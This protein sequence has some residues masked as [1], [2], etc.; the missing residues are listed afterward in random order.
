MKYRFQ[1]GGSTRQSTP[2]GRRN[3]KSMYVDYGFS[4][5]GD[6]RRERYL[7]NFYTTEAMR[8]QA[9]KLRSL[10]VDEPLKAQVLSATD[11]VLSDLSQRGDYENM[12]TAVSRANTEYNKLAAPLTEN[13]ANYTS[14]QERLQ[15]D[16]EE[17]RLNSRDYSR[18]MS[19]AKSTY[20]GLEMD[21][22]GN[23]TNYF[24]GVDP[25]YDPDIPQLMYKALDGLVPDAQVI[26]G[27]KPE[28]NG[29]GSKYAIKTTDGIK[30][31]DAARVDGIMDMVMNEPSVLSY[32]Q[33]GAVLDSYDMD[34]ETARGYLQQ[35]IANTQ[36]N[37]DALDAAIAEETNADAKAQLVAVKNQLNKGV[38]ELTS[39]AESDDPLRAYQ[40][41]LIRKENARYR[42][43]AEEKYTYEQTET[44]RAYAYNDI[45]KAKQLAK[46]TDENRPGTKLTYNGEAYQYESGLGSNTYEVVG[47]MQKLNKTIEEMQDDRNQNW[48]SWGDDVKDQWD[49]NYIDQLMQLDLHHMVL[50]QKYGITSESELYN[51][52]GYQ[53]AVKKYEDAVAKYQDLLVTGDSEGGYIPKGQTSGDMYLPGSYGA[54]A[55]QSPSDFAM[56]QIAN[57]EKEL[58]NWLENNAMADPDGLM[59]T[60]TPIFQTAASMFDP[61]QAKS[62]E[63]W[64]KTNWGS[65]PNLMAFT[66]NANQQQTIPEILGPGKWKLSGDIGLNRWAPGPND[67]LVEVAYVEEESGARETVRIPLN[68]I[69]INAAELGMAYTPM[70]NFRQHVES[71]RAAGLKEYPVPVV[72][73]EGISGTAIVRYSQD[74]KDDRVVFMWDNGYE[75]KEEMYNGDILEESFNE[76][77]CSVISKIPR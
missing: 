11:Q 14:Y 49:R 76:G 77:R 9:N 64:I 59:R 5:V 28:L 58:D 19:M 25:V 61:K 72:N 26:K 62:T 75:S 54:G 45:W 73:G 66:N 41:Q 8:D 70:D 37:I 46:L 6:I 42:Q 35:D 17:G 2:S 32:I 60:Q 52:P 38:V 74:G 4:D 36:K 18:T 24:Q 30:Y 48:D 43:G 51:N 53:A 33:R 69:G 67:K 39:G 21:E 22:F 44:E 20:G 56:G 27:S 40:E 50:S 34:P 63:D 15:K 47:N 7:Q 57:A 31:V 71:G 12:T 23:A 10:E 29:D 1:K 13:L 3:I 16:Y 68:Q 65:P 55:G